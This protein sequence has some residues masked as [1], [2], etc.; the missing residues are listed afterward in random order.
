MNISEKELSSLV[1]SLCDLLKTFDKGGNCLQI[2]SPKSNIEI[3]SKDSSCYHY[4]NDIIE[5]P[6]IQ[7]PFS[8]RFGNNNSYV[9]LIKIF[10]LNVNQF[11]LTE[12]VNLNHRE[13]HQIYKNRY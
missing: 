10:D 13:N 9:F 5:H 4:Y 6:Y 3:A 2:P 1:D 8:F 7:R 11:I 12:I